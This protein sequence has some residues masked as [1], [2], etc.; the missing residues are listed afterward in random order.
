M[1]DYVQEYID[2]VEKKELI[3]SQTIKQL[4]TRHKKDLEEGRFIY[5]LE[6]P[7]RVVKFLELLPDLT[8]GER[9]KLASFQKFIIGLMYG[10]RKPNGTRRFNEVFITMA[11]KQGKS[12]L[13]SGVALYE[14][15]YAKSPKLDRQIFCAASTS[16]Q[17]RIVYSMISKQ[18]GKICSQSKKIRRSVHITQNQIKYKDEAF[19]KPLSNNTPALDGYNPLVAVVDEVASLKQN[20]EMISVLKTGMAQQREPLLFKIST[21][22]TNL[23]ADMY[24][25]DL[26]FA[27]KVLSGEITGQAADSL[28]PIIYEQ[29]SKEELDDET[30]WIKSNPLLEVESMNTILMG[31]L[32]TQLQVARETNDSKIYTK[33]FNFWVSDNTTQQFVDMDSWLS[34]TVTEQL[35]LT[36]KDLYIGLDLSARGD[37]SSVSWAVPLPEQQKIFADSFSFV[38]Y[39]GSIEQ[40][41][42]TENVDYRA[43]EKQGFCKITT[44]ESGMV[45]YVEV[46]EFIREL[47][48]S[49]NFNLKG[50]FYDPYAI[51]MVITQLEDE[52]GDL[53]IETRQGYKTLSSPIQKLRQD[54]LDGVLIHNS[55]P[56]LNRAMANAELVE[57]NNALMIDK[58][59]GT[60]KLKIDPAA[61]LLNT[62]VE[63]Q[64]EDFKPKED[65]NEYFTKDF[66][67]F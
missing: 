63:L 23:S 48:A 26:P 20:S 32:R 66:S 54:V 46:V 17:A 37:L 61:A 42:K 31:Y 36:G 62:Y 34:N 11:R 13:V 51:Q 58:K 44:K 40:K 22:G 45:D 25:T 43:L 53:L 5:N 29:D 47:I 16:Q 49:H 14:A 3:V 10:W 59:N 15:M 60:Y 27:R 18:L 6:E 65:I 67:L 57:N 4:I 50:I 21:A 2:K 24:L 19:I 8:T 12:I 35:D 33:N 55:N 1:T 30:M 28:L 64:F 38:G 39:Q 52:Y 56:L 9:T 7:E 41:I